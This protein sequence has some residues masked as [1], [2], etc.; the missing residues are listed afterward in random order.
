MPTRDLTHSCHRQAQLQCFKGLDAPRAPSARGWGRFH[1]PDLDDD[2]RQGFRARL[3]DATPADLRA[4]AAQYL[5]TPAAQSAE[6]IVGNAAAVGVE[7]AE[8]W[9]VLGPDLQPLGKAEGA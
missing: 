4:V 2:T 9:A 3:L 1:Q 7:A 6:C 8:G 5:A